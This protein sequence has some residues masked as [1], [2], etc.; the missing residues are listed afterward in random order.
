VGVEDESQVTSVVT[1]SKEG[2]V[3]LPITHDVGIAGVIIYS[4]M[5]DIL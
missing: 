3:G 4:V 2:D 5:N 1:G